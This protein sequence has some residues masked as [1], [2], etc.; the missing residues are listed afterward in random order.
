MHLN[1]GECLELILAN[2]EGYVIDDYWEP[3]YFDG[4]TA[5]ALVPGFGPFSQYRLPAAGR[6]RLSRDALPL[7]PELV[8]TSSAT[9]LSAS[10]SPSL[11]R[12]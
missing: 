8:S 6:G 12:P 3:P 10:R 4:E 2:R 11:P 1:D 5:E 9:S 7:E